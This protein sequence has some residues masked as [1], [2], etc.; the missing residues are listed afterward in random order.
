M[1]KILTK[2]E[3]VD[4]LSSLPIRSPS[5]QL[6]AWATQKNTHDRITKILTSLG[7]NVTNAQAQR[8]NALGL[9]YE[10]LQDLRSS[11][12]DKEEFGEALLK[13]GVKSKPVREKLQKLVRPRH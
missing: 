10:A 12:T 7:K 1:E 4:V 5:Q 2:T 13:S 8:L 11:C 3:L 9:S 6:G